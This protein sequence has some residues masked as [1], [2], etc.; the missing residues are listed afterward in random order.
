[1]KEGTHNK[2]SLLDIKMLGHLYL[3]IP[4]TAK[5]EAVVLN[6]S[7][8]PSGRTRVRANVKTRDGQKISSPWVEVFL[9]TSAP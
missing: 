5:G 8:L 2:V 4:I 6:F 3:L 7:N 1:M 9:M